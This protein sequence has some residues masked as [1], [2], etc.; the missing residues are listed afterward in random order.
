MAVTGQRKLTNG[1]QNFGAVPNVAG[2][3]T[4]PHSTVILNDVPVLASLTSTVTDPPAA[5]A[6]K[7]IELVFQN[8]TDA[9]VG[10]RIP[11]IDEPLSRDGPARPLDLFFGLAARP[12]GGFVAIVGDRLYV[13]PAQKFDS[14]AHPNPMRF[15]PEYLLTVVGDKPAEVALP[16]LL[17]AA[18]P[19][20]I[21]LRREV[22]GVTLDQKKWCVK[23]DPEPMLISL[24]DGISAM[25]SNSQ[26]GPKPGQAGNILDTYLADVNRRF[27]RLTGRKP[28]GIPV[29]VPVS[30]IAQD[31]NL[32]TAEA[33]VGFFL[34]VPLGPVK[35]NASALPAG[36]QKGPNAAPKVDSALTP[37]QVGD[38]FREQGKLQLRIEMLEKKIDELNKKIDELT[39]ALDAKKPKKD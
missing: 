22:K 10:L 21:S 13:L 34:D 33:D 27:E 17:D 7:R 20:E 26:A 32:R 38:L 35:A 8:L 9:K 24:T 2:A 16:A 37:A 25:A 15:S 36:G 6:R 12:G 23:V 19:V 5:R 11:I 31:K 30:V 14:K 4:V 1:L 18:A 3:G 29:W 39:K 28:S